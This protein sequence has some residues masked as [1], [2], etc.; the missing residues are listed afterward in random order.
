LAPYHRPLQSPAF[1]DRGESTAGG[2]AAQ[3]PIRWAAFTMISASPHGNGHLRRISI[4][5]AG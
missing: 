1:A 4:V 2:A 5:L 3:R